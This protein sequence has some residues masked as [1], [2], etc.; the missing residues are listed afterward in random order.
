MSSQEDPDA[1]RK[2]HDIVVCFHLCSCAE[3]RY[4]CARH[5]LAYEKACGRACVRW[6]VVTHPILSAAHSV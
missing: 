3:E 4:R 5:E 1:P 6:M 2:E